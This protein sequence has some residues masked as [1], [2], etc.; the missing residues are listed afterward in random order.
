MKRLRC[1]KCDEWLAFDETKYSTGQSLVFMCEH[2]GKQFSVRLGGKKKQIERKDQEGNQIEDGSLK[3]SAEPCGHI[4]VIENVF[5]YRQELP[6]YIGENIIGRRCKGTEINVPIESGDMSMDRRHCM[7]QIKRNKQ[8]VP[9]FTLRDAP[10][11]TGTFLNN[12]LLGPKDRVRLDD[13][14]IVTCGAT[15]FIVHQ[16]NL[17]EE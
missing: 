6:L 3:E 8:G 17:E 16:E 10:S 7:I 12:D 14:A 2:C 5:G 1:P 13:G 9:V 11:L 4:V 15:T